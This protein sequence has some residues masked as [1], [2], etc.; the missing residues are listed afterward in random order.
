MCSSKIEKWTK[1]G[2]DEGHVRWY[3]GGEGAGNVDRVLTFPAQALAE[4]VTEETHYVPVGMMG[5][6]AVHMNQK[7]PNPSQKQD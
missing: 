4:Q 2:G 7:Q 5:N 3:P 6:A 1:R